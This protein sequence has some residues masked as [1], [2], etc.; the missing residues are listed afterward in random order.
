MLLLLE[1]RPRAKGENVR[2]FLGAPMATASSVGAGL[3]GVWGGGFGGTAA[4][5]LFLI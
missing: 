4:G 5:W 3:K 1:R 2:G